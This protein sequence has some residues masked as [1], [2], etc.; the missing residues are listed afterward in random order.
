MVKKNTTQSA[1]NDTPVVQATP[2]PTTVQVASVPATTPVQETKSRK[3]KGGAVPAPVQTTPAP[4]QTTP[5]PVQTTPA[6]VQTTSAPVQTTPTPV[7]TTPTPVQS[8]GSKKSK[9]TVLSAGSVEQPVAPASSSVVQTAGETA[10]PR[11]TATKTPRQTKAMKATDTTPK[12]GGKKVVPTVAVQAEVPAEVP[13]EGEEKGRFFKYLYN[14]IVSGRF[15]GSKPKQAANKALT[16]IVKSHSETGDLTNKMLTFSIIECTRGSKKKQYNYQGIRR[17]LD[18]PIKVTIK[19][20]LL[21][22]VYKFQNKTSKLKEQPVAT[23]S[24]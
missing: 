8:A 2:V 10:K 14:G 13:A 6:P 22:I 1:K 20:K 5:A 15:S 21:P 7:Q 9:K 23:A 19:N 17:A 24:A 12:R 3:Q 11:K 16:S 4:V 18:T